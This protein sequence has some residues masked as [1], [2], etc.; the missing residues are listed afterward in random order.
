MQFQ[1]KIGSTGCSKLAVLYQDTTA[2]PQQ[3]LAM[4][5]VRF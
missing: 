5:A 2:L 1:A 4:H 3:T